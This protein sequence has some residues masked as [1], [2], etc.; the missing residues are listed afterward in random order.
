MNITMPFPDFLSSALFRP[1]LS[2]ACPAIPCC[3]PGALRP[4]T[5]TAR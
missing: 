3:F 1:R 2:A 4:D 5:T